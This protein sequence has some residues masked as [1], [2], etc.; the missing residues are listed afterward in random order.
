[1]QFVFAPMWGAL[2]DRIGRRPVLLVSLAGSTIS[3]LCF[4]IADSISLL[5]VSRAVG[6]ICAA[7]ISAAQAYIADIT[8]PE[9]RA[10]GMG[11]IGAAF[12]LGFTL[13]PPLGGIAAHSL[14]LAAP[15]LIAAG[16]CGLNFVLAVFRLAESLPVER[17][18]APRAW[19]WF[20]LSRNMLGVVRQSSSLSALIPAFFLITFAFS[21]F[22]QT[23]TLLIQARF[24]FSTEEASFRGGI[25]LMW[26]GVVGVIVQG[27]L[28][29][30]LVPRFGERKLILLGAALY[31]VVL[32]VLPFLPTYGS[33]FVVGAVLAFGAGILNP[34][35]SGAISKN[36]HPSSQGAVLGLNQGLGS[37]A[38][39][40]GPLCGLLSF[41][42][43]PALPFL[44][45]GGV[46]LLAAAAASRFEGSEGST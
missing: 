10:Q 16:L 26:L 42:W 19:V 34:S 25:A 30:T 14:G 17:R 20:P 22:E 38:R 18:A 43:H 41:E 13:G 28:I 37:L 8:P 21:N 12:G 24:G 46:S 23:F 5:I 45:A 31:A 32:T 6:G 36:T 3:Y 44:I 2:S 4:G 1:M 7:N 9:K 35:L 27:G 15:G 39:T 33:Y 11:L 40:V 29:R